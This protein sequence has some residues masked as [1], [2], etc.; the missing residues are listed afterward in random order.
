MAVVCKQRLLQCLLCLGLLWLSLAHAQPVMQYR[1]DIPAQPLAGA[2]DRYAVVTGQPVLF[3][4]VLVD[5]VVSGTVAGTYTPQSAL[6][7]MLAGTGLVVE[8]ITAGIVQ[9]FVLKAA[10]GVSSGG[11]RSNDQAILAFDAHVQ[12]Q[13]LH[14]LCAHEATEPGNYRMLLQF[15]VG[16]S[17]RITHIAVLTPTGSTNRDAM[18]VNALE[19]VKIA[20]ALPAGLKQPTT[21]LFLP[22]S[23]T[24]GNMCTKGA[25]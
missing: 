11:N 24:A 16:A 8:A 15:E 10:S 19:Q 22:R 9:T 14:A 23:Q 1:F 3:P 12:S 5:G 13:V 25:P 17:G 18:I 20:H 21:M 4:S 7:E 2:L 6:Q